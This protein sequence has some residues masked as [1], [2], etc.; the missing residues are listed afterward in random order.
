MG[1]A[2]TRISIRCDCGR[3]HDLVVLVDEPDQVRSMRP[4]AT[5]GAGNGLTA[6]EQ[7]VLRHVAAGRTDRETARLLGISVNRVRHGVR[8]AVAHLAARTRSEAVYLASRRGQLDDAVAP[9]RRPTLK[10]T[11]LRA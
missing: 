4:S 9:V 6:F 7:D 11:H 1:N 8:G 3:V 10:Q 5:I 2:M